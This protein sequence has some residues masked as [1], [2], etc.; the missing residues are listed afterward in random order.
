MNK[1]PGWIKALAAFVLFAALYGA[2]QLLLYLDK[3]ASGKVGLD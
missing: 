2:A 1:L 3:T